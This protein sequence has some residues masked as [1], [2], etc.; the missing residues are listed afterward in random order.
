MDLSRIDLTKIDSVLANKIHKIALYY[1]ANPLASFQVSPGLASFMEDESDRILVRAANRVGKSVTAAAKLAKLMLKY[2]NRRYR[3]IGVDYGQAVGV[4]SK[5]L[6]DFLPKDSLAEGCTYTI[7][8]GWIHQLIRLKN[9][10]TCEIRSNDQKAISHAGSSLH[11]VW[12]DEPP[13]PEIFLEN[14]TRVMDTNGFLWVTATPIGRPCGYL[15]DIVTAPDSVWKEHV[16]EFSHKNCPWYSKEQVDKWILEAQAA[17]WA[18]RQKIFGEWEGETVDRIFTGFD[19]D[20]QIKPGDD[21]PE[22]D[23]FIGIGVDHGESVGKQVA[24]LCVW[25]NTHIYV[26]DEV[27]SETHTTPEMDA[28][29]ILKCLNRWGWALS[30]VQRIVGDINSAGKAH[31]GSK[32]N[33]LLGAALCQQAGYR[34]NVINISSPNK[35]KGSV[36]Y[37][38][39]LLNAGF[40]RGQLKISTRC[41]TLTHA[42]KH[43]NGEESLKHSIDAA[44]Y[45]LQPVLESWSTHLPGI[46]KIKINGGR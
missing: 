36:E 22:E 35:G 4:I 43:Y 26:I 46:N 21:L 33:E 9:G 37:G 14:I 12:C 27:I 42:L 16:V 39:K 41:K 24:L 17:P 7:T 8:S 18:Y 5:L 11:G 30:D 23:F 34:Q 6:F 19:V 28:K 10:T 32:V 1:Q 31:A 13:K 25:T 45:I 15:K 20:C 40:L 44:R 38:E 3:A 2:P 29:A